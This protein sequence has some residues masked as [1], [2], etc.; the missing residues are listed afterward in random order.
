[1]ASQEE[2]TTPR[3]RPGGGDDADAEVKPEDF[4]F[5]ILAPGGLVE[6]AAGVDMC[7]AGEVFS[8]GKLVPFRLSSATS[9]DALLLLR[10]D[11]L[12]SSSTATAAS[13]SD[14]SSS[15]D[16]GSA[17]FS[18]SSI[19]LSRSASLK[20][21]SSSSDSAPVGLSHSTAQNGP[22]CAPPGRSLA[23]SS[24][25]YAHPSPSP[26]PPPPPRRSRTGGSAVSAARRRSTGSA[27]PPAAAWSVI[28][29]GVVGAPGLVYPP[30][31]GAE[32]RKVA[33][34]R[35]GVISRS[36]RFDQ[37]MPAGNKE[38]PLAADKK[39]KPVFGWW[40]AGL[41]CS[42]SAD[43]VA[44]RLAAARRRQRRKA[45]QTKK[46]GEVD[47]G[48]GA[49]LGSSSGRRSSS[50]LPNAKSKNSVKR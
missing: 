28:R 23:S 11:S 9:A 38:Q 40:G 15:S 48:H 8:G 39:K 2:E 16:S 32:A 25:F 22:A 36:A 49:V 50:Q 30:P 37:P 33:R 18:S 20:S 26:R 43:D 42:C 46:G 31:H 45:E 21:S 3:C 4:E 1:M 19:G 29:L 7:V 13:T 6:D 34:S 47:S 10:S 24:W 12:D 41:A 14:F 44:P 5:C 35:G 27:P 17:S